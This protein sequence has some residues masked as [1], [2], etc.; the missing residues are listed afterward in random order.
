MVR[1]EQH[2]GAVPE[3]RD[4]LV[5][6]PRPPA[7]VA[8]LGAAQR[9]QVVQGVAGVL[10]RAQRAHP[11]EVEVHLRRRLGARRQLELDLDPVD[12]A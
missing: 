9:D 2:V 11:R 7:G 6:V 4:R 8:D 1:R 10:R 12:G 5:Q 3:E